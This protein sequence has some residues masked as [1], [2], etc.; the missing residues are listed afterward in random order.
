MLESLRS[1][2]YSGKTRPESFRR[3]SLQKLRKEIFLREDDILHALYMD[4]GKPPAEAYVSEIGFV[5]SEIKYALKNLHSWM[6]KRLVKTPLMFRPAKSFIIPVPRG[7]VLILGPWN[8]PF[9]LL[10]APL[11]G[12]LSAGNCAVLKPSE[13]APETSGVIEEIINNIFPQGHCCVV[14]GDSE[15]S[16]ELVG[17]KWDHIFFTGSTGIGKK[18]MTRAAENLVPVTLELGGKN[19]CMVFND[20]NVSVSAERIAWGKFLNS[21][22]TCIAPDTVYCHESIYS[23]FIGEL[24]KAVLR[25]FGENPET[26]PD[27]GRIINIRHIKR[28][29]EYLENSGKVLTGGQFDEKS[30]YF[31]PTIMLDIPKE[32]IIMK[33]EIFGPVLPVLKFKDTDILLSKLRKQPCPLAVYIFTNNRSIQEKIILELPSGSVGIN[34]TIKQAATQYLPFGGAGE[35]GIG[36]YHGKASFDAFSN[37]KSIMQTGY[38]GTRFHFPPYGKGVKALK[39]IYRLLY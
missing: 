17:M 12:A 18:I 1:F 4:L 25:F 36:N 9:Q 38:R 8:Y 7:V 15:K 11:V 10:M 39:K 5:L 35:S 32:S 22:Q 23:V 37:Y 19:P 3:N 13:Y 34:D 20:A 27:Y 14:P 21:G 28:L 16:R 29:S 6:K 2:Y 30:L 26:S 31:S 24:Q 33:E